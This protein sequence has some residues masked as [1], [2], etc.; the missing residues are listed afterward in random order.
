MT[1]DLAPDQSLSEISAALKEAE[2]HLSTVK[3]GVDELRARFARAVLEE[4][5]P[6]HRLAV[7]ARYW[8]EDKPVLIQLLG[9]D[10]VPDIDDFESAAMAD[11]L[12][13]AQMRAWASAS[14]AVAAIGS[15]DDLSALLEQGEEHEDWIEFDLPLN[16]DHESKPLPS[17]VG[18]AQDEKETR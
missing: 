3:T 18:G 1:T 4:S 16:A 14:E 6:D 2:H 5:Y 15:D 7:F 8:Y 12:S 10:G 13:G 9:P 11:E 17:S